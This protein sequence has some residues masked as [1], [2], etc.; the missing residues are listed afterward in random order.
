[1]EACVGLRGSVLANWARRTMPQR[2]QPAS[3]TGN[4]RA[5]VLEGGGNLPPTPPP[6]VAGLRLGGGAKLAA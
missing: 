3:T 6:L 5:N 1:M 4:P 2:A